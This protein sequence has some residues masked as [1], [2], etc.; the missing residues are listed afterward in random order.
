[1]LF[2]LVV[3]VVFVVITGLTLDRLG[4]FHAYVAPLGWFLFFGPAAALLRAGCALRR[5]A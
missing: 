2:G 1:V 3:A 5:P 4:T